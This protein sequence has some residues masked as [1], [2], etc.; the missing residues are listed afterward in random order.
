MGNYWVDLIAAALGIYLFDAGLRGKLETH[1]RGGGRK[2]I[3]RVNALWLRI[4]LAA[5]GVALCV[6][7]GL[8]VHRKLIA[9]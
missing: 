1:R 4:V 3:R 2:L 6:W 5:S 9:G 7:V 8:D